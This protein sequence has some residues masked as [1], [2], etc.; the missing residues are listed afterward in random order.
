MKIYLIGYMGSG[1]STMGQGL[2]EAF[3]ISWIDLDDE[4]ESRYKISIPTFFEKYGE[5]AFRELEHK[6]LTDISV[7]PD[8]VVS[9]GGGTPCFH[10]NMDLMNRTGITVY[11]DAS[12]ELI[13]SRIDLSGRKRPVFLRMKGHD[14]LQNITAHLNTR[15]MFYEQAHLTIEAT[16]P[17]IQ[18]LKNQILNFSGHIIV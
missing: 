5:T 16:Q 18:V 2:A 8:V 7:T 17:D 14:S 15:V 13:L 12:P 10:G 6:V 9:T 11:L 1:K 4:F 3:G